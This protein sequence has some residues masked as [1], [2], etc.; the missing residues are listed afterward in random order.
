MR[1]AVLLPAIFAVVVVP[2]ALFVISGAGTH[3]SPLL[4]YLPA[5]PWWLVFQ[6]G[7]F[8][9]ETGALLVECGINAFLL[10]LLGAAVDRRTSSDKR[11]L[12]RRTKGHRNPDNDG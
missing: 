1:N 7:S 5:A 2:L 6:G 4:L 11:D 9:S 12:T 8:V 10:Y 3:M